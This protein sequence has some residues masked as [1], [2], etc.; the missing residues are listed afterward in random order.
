MIQLTPTQEKMLGVLSDGMRHTRQELHAC[1]SDEL[2]PLSNIQMHISN[3]RKV[4]R[5]IGQDIICEYYRRK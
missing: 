3:I 2:A 5:P 4:L 1:L